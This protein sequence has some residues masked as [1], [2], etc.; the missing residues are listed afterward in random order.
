MNDDTIANFLTETNQLCTDFISD[1]V[2]VLCQVGY[3]S[4]QQVEIMSEQSLYG[5]GQTFLA[6]AK[7]LFLAVQ[8]L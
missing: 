3:A 1:H 8:A 4:C 2:H 7:S 6:T 5:V